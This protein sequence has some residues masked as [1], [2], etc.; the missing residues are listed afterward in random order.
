[1]ILKKSISKKI[2]NINKEKT[3]RRTHKRQL[4]SGGDIEIIMFKNYQ[5]TKPYDPTTNKKHL[6][7]CPMFR[8]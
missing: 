4:P 8:L 5:K 7:T 3:K 1:M 6:Q 2:N